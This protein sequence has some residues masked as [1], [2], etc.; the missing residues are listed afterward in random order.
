MAVTAGGTP[1]PQ[2]FVHIDVRSALPAL[3]TSRST[4]RVGTDPMT[5][6]PYGVWDDEYVRRR[7]SAEAVTLLCQPHGA[8]IYDH[9]PRPG[10]KAAVGSTGSTSEP[11]G[12]L[13][14]VR[15]FNRNR[16]LGS[17]AYR[18]CTAQMANASVRGS[19]RKI[20][21]AL[22]CRTRT[23]TEAVAIEIVGRMH[24]GQPPSRGAEWPRP[25]TAL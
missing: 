1:A 11:F 8:H 9:H 14:V 10:C 22:P 12:I 4:G 13:E 16:Q 17:A 20:S 18:V 2:S 23:P 3:D 15:M 5:P 6:M 25:P 7:R 21:A 24:G 19:G